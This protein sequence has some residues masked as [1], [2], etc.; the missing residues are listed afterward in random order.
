M[1]RLAMLG[2]ALAASVTIA[3][4]QTAVPVRLYVFDGGILESDPGRYHLTKEDVGETR[5]SVACYQFGSPPT[6]TADVG[7]PAPCP[8]RNG[9]RRGSRWRRGSCWPT[10]PS[11]G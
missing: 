4:A 9:R 1:I 3:L 10:A 5:L 2:A 6:R 8:T 11:G 7:Q